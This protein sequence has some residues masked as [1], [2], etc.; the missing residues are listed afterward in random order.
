MGVHTVVWNDPH[1]ITIQHAG[2]SY[3]LEE[4]NGTPVALRFAASH[5][6]II[7]SSFLFCANPS[8]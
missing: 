7:G 4:L 2:S 5:I 3:T 6:K 1:R 8:Q